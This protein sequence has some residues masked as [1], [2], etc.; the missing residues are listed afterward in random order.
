MSIRPY[1]KIEDAAFAITGWIGSVPSIITHT[2][3]FIVCFAA[4]GL[5]VLRF[6]EMLLAL[7]TAVSL[8]AIYLAI[9]IQMTVNRTTESIE[10]VEQDIDEMQE[11]VGEI[12]EDID[13]M[14]KDVD[15]MQ[16]D[17]DEMQ[18]D[19]EQLHFEGIET[20]EPTV[21]PAP[22][23][24]DIHARLKGLLHDIEQMGKVR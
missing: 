2:V 20:P 23:L 9:F 14:Q 12:Q 4:V 16:E 15:E 17:I 19:V 6:D 3:I 13:E 10:E 22:N 7:T 11:D 18:E 5:G 21:S 24:A 1:T 8:E